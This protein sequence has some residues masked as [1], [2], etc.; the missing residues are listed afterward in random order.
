MYIASTAEDRKLVV[1][2]LTSHNV[3]CTKVQVTVLH[4]SIVR[5]RLYSAPCTESSCWCS[6]DRRKPRILVWHGLESQRE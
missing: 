4:T 6:P 5:R 2:D 1:W 3:V